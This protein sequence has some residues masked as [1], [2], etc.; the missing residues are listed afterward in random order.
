MAEVHVQLLEY[1]I[2][3]T[4]I[5]EIQSPIPYDDPDQICDFADGSVGIVQTQWFP[6]SDRAS[7]YVES[8][9]YADWNPLRV[10]L[11]MDFQNWTLADLRRFTDV[12]E[13]IPQHIRPKLRTRG[14][15]VKHLNEWVARQP[16]TRFVE[17]E[18]WETV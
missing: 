15:Y 11:S 12:W 5:Y 10:H 6:T 16:L 14:A 2:F 9:R 8:R 18:G 7:S 3:V 4:M 13:A 17:W 1:G